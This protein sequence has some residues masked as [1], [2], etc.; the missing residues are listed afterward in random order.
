[1]DLHQPGQVVPFE[2]S[3]DV[4]EFLVDASASSLHEHHEHPCRPSYD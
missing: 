1:M 2:A 4:D 3:G